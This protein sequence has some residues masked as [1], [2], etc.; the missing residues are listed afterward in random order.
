MFNVPVPPSPGTPV[1]WWLFWFA[2][3]VGV[4]TLVGL[5]FWRVLKRETRD[6]DAP[7]GGE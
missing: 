6:P 3:A 1:L 2:A 5:W 7:G 4:Y